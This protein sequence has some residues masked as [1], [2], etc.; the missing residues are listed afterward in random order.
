MVSVK[1]NI[2]HNGLIRIAAA[3]F[4]AAICLLS[5]S[6]DK[7]YVPSM[8]RSKRPSLHALDVQTLVSDSGVVRYRVNTK[9]WFVYD[10]AEEPYWDFPVGLHLER[11][12][13]QMKVD[14]EI[15]SK[16]AIYKTEP[17]LWDLRDSVKAVNLEGEQF[18]CDQLFWDEKAERVYSNGRIK[19]TQKDRVIYG[20]G[21]DSNQTLTKYT[22]KSPEGIFP[23]K[24]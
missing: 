17:K 23:I 16:Y 1:Q 14:A 22:I 13:P 8:E 12:D 18:E 10:K 20:K 6:D 19:I 4:V 9:E 7:D 2:F 11:F 15:R 21:F 5:C 3:V 24:E